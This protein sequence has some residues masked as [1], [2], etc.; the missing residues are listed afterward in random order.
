MIPK[1]FFKNQALKIL[2]NVKLTTLVSEDL[3]KA[4]RKTL[5]ISE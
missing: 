1:N 2:E 3:F 4:K 5:F